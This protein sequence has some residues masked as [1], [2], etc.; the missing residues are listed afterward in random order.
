MGKMLVAVFDGEAKTTVVGAGVW[1]RSQASAT[2]AA[3]TLPMKAPQ[4]P[5]SYHAYFA[6][7]RD[8][9]KAMLF[10][11]DVAGNV[12]IDGLSLPARNNYLFARAMMGRQFAYPTVLARAPRDPTSWNG[13]ELLE[14]VMGRLRA[15]AIF[16][17]ITATAVATAAWLIFAGMNEPSLR[18]E[19]TLISTVASLP[20]ALP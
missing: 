13:P 15:T 4:V 2:T 7:L 20:P 6:S 11:C 8:E 3:L 9:G 18:F 1:P 19:P 5:A 17:G 12:D 10:P 14:K 16:T